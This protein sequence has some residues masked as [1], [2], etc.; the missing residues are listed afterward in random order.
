[1]I[2]ACQLCKQCNFFFDLLGVT[3]QITPKLLK[4]EQKLRRMEVIQELLNAIDND[5]VFLERVIIN[6]EI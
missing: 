2:L 1:M 3:Q 6:D 5:P 4:F